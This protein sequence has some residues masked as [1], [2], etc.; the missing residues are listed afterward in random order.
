MRYRDD[1]KVSFSRQ[2][3]KLYGCDNSI[4]MLKKVDGKGDIHFVCGKSNQ[5]PYAQNTFDLV[6]SVAVFHHLGSEETAADTAREMMRVAKYGGKVIIWDANP[7]NPYWLILF[8]RV[9]YDRGVGKPMSFVKLISRIKDAGISNIEVF[10]S[11]WIP[12]FAPKNIFLLF[13]IFENIMEHIPL[14]NLFSA[15]NVVV[16]TKG[17]S[18]HV[19]K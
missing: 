2:D 18:T 4:E 7:L 6:I 19:E 14:L 8:K 5:L 16:L 17:K 13:K 3:L 1:P 11:G 9:P 10:K 15:H 12:D